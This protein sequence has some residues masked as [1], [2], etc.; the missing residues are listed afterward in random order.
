KMVVAFRGQIGS[1]PTS[2]ADANWFSAAGVSAPYALPGCAGP[3]NVVGGVNVTP[4]MPGLDATYD[5]GPGTSPLLLYFV[6]AGTPDGVT[7][8]SGNAARTPLLKFTGFT[9]GGHLLFHPV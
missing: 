4:T 2:S 6:G 3:W 5:V 7:M 1:E 8:Y 9:S